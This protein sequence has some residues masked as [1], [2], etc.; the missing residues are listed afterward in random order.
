MEAISDTYKST[1]TLQPY[2][3]SRI[4]IIIIIW[5]FPLLLELWSSFFYLLKTP[6]TKKFQHSLSRTS[7]NTQAHARAGRFHKTINIRTEVF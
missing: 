6:R 1:C 2:T 5:E 3:Y 7:I 4:I